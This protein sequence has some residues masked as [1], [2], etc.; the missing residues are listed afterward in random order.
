MK[1]FDLADVVNAADIW[2]SDLA[3]DTDFVI[4]PGQSA[5]LAS[6]TVGEKLQGH[7]LA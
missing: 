7:G 6:K 3:R 4:E 5:V 1:A 2:V